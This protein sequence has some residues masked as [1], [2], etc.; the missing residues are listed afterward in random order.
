MCGFLDMGFKGTP[1]IWEK[2]YRDRQTIW[3]RLNRTLAN[4]E[5]LIW[6][7]GSIVHHL[8]S[9]TLDHSPLW[10]LSENLEPVNPEKPFRFEEMW[11]AKKGCSY[12]SKSKW[13]KH[14]NSNTA[15]GIVSK[16]KDCGKTLKQWSHKNFE[17]ISKEL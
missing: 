5:W 10:I 15:S 9:S 17:S 3:E 12:T 8:N 6:F 4:N 1:F 7:M 11:L 13:F 2:F 16:I 14:R